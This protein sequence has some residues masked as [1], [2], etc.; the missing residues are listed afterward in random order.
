M[1][2]GLVISSGAI[3]GFLILGFLDHTDVS[4]IKYFCGCSVG[5]YICMLL[6]IGYTPLEIITY[7]CVNDISQLFKDLNPLMLKD[8]Y[9]MVNVDL[10]LE[11]IETMIKYKIGYVPTFK[12]LYREFNKILICPAYNISDNIKE[13]LSVDTYPDMPISKACILSS[14]IPFLFS[15]VEYNGKC[16]IDGAVFD[17]F[18]LDKLLEYLD[19][20]E[21]KSNILG[22]TFKDKKGD[23][24]D[25]FT[26]YVKKIV[27]CLTSK[28]YSLRDNV[29]VRT[30]SFNY[31]MLEFNVDTKTKI[32]MYADG[33]KQSIKFNLLDKNDKEC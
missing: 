26:S 33:Y 8:Y 10:M 12:D 31:E 7:L 27:S 24:I 15:K 28:K 11:Y 30:L 4:N 6:A 5:S 18:P 21:I 19:R 25:N 17:A 3:K 22:I 16:Y 14:N 29:T 9:G 13:Y 1:Y 32:D 2:D 20:E 23:T